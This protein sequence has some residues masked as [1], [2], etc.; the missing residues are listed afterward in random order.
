M[1]YHASVNTLPKLY[2]VRGDTEKLPFKACSLDLIFLSMVLEHIENKEKAMF[3]GYRILNVGGR[4]AIRMCDKTQ[5]ARTSWYRWFPTALRMDLAKMPDPER[6]CGILDSAGFAGTLTYKFD[7]ERVE[8]PAR[9]IARIRGK[10]YSALQSM[11]QEEFESGLSLLE[12][13]LSST[14]YFR[15]TSPCTLVVGRKL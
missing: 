8:P 15:Y 7:D 5:L 2:W 1:L 11:P 12:K 6:V 10:A 14:R 4:V 13:E 3:E 9:Y